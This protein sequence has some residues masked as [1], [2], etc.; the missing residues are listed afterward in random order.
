MKFILDN[1]FKI[2][3]VFSFAVYLFVLLKISFFYFVTIKKWVKSEAEITN[4][5]I[6]FYRSDKD[7]DTEGWK[8]KVIYSFICNSVIYKGDCITK[9]L[10]I[11][12]PFKDMANQNN[13]K[14]G[15]KINIT[16]NPNNPIESVIDDKFDLMNIILPLAFYCLLYCFIF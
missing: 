13:F 12:V 11:L 15:Q 5:E 9:N 10:K 7:S 1:I 16:F 8:E 3:F 14:C 6:E 4:S 2:A